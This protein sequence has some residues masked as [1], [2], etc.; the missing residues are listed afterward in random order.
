MQKPLKTRRAPLMKKRAST[1]LV[2]VDTPTGPMFGWAIELE[3]LIL[4]QSDPYTRDHARAL[5]DGDRFR[6][7]NWSRLGD[8][9]E[10]I[11]PAEIQR[12][13]EERMA[14]RHALVVREEQELQNAVRAEITS[15]RLAVPGEDVPDLPVG[16]IVHP[17]PRSQRS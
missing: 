3:G 10:G 14:R 4:K 11:G 13:Y 2:R 16:A 15:I 17:Q 9:V 6:H 12:R 7:E 1:A 5:L 8:V